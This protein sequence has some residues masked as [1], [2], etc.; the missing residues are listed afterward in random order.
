MF[1][2]HEAGIKSYKYVYAHKNFR[3]STFLQIYGLEDKIQIIYI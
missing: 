1:K 3:F 2:P